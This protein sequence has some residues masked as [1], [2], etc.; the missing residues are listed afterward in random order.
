MMPIRSD[1][2]LR[3]VTLNLY[4]ADVEKFEQAFGHGW[5]EK[6]RALVNDYAKGMRI[7][8]LQRRK[9]GDLPTGYEHKDPFWPDDL[10]ESFNDQ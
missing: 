8:K 3:K 7:V 6:V 2:P 5:T 1:D 10:E 9:L 4:E